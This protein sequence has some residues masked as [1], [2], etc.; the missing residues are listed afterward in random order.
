MWLI[1][2]CLRSG[3]SPPPDLKGIETVKA[4]AKV[5][6]KDG[7]LAARLSFRR[8]AR[9][10]RHGSGLSEGSQGVAR[11]PQVESPE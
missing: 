4:R 10:T 9:A 1:I 6:A 7:R 2:L 11:S 8:A 3:R 5:P